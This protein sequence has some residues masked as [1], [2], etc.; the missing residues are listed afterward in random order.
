MDHISN[1]SLTI[2]ARLTKTYMW[3]WS[4]LARKNLVSIIPTGRGWNK[5]VLTPTGFKKGRKH[6]NGLNTKTR[7]YSEK[8]A[9]FVTAVS[10]SQ[11]VSAIYAHYPEMKANSVFS[12]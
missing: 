12:N 6:L 3:F 5:Y 2:T 10:F 1:L 8:L 9:E 11:L 7:K 4:K